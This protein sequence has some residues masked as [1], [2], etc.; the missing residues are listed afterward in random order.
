MSKFPPNSSD[1]DSPEGLAEFRRQSEVLFRATAAGLAALRKTGK[2]DFD[3]LADE[4][5]AAYANFDAAVSAFDPH[6]V[7]CGR[8]CSACCYLTVGASF[9][10]ALVVAAYVRDQRPDLIGKLE[11]TAGKVR[12]YPSRNQRFRAAIPCAFLE[13]DGACAVYPARPVGCRAAH[14]PDA[15]LCGPF[16]DP[17]GVNQ[18]PQHDETRATAIRAMLE[19][20]VL[21]NMVTQR[22]RA[23]EFLNGVL[24]ALEALDTGTLE[25]FD[26]WF[27]HEDE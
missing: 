20:T 1:L 22:P 14:S 2:S 13:E 4:T 24:C 7:A 15:K 10:E 21:N 19:L 3:I 12:G 11:K 9:G 8:G 25:P 26:D 17:D 16:N 6:P 5:K 27:A 18:I 23:G